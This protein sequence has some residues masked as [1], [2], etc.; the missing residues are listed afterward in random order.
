[1]NSLFNLCTFI[2]LTNG[3]YLSNI[4]IHCPQQIV[5]IVENLNNNL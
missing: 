1:M 2:S 3:Y 5:L 4:Q